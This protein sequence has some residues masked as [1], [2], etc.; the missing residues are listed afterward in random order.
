[1]SPEPRTYLRSQAVIFLVYVHLPPIFPD[2]HLLLLR[3]PPHLS[4]VALISQ[5]RGRSQEEAACNHGGKEG[6]TKEQKGVPCEMAPVGGCN[7]V[8]VGRWA[9]GFTLEDWHF[10]GDNG[11]KDGERMTVL[12]S[13]PGKEGV[14]EWIGAR[15]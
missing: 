4:I 8:I 13:T 7:G 11:V 3:Q 5:G 14:C 10:V 1:M 6:E 2:P 12:V 9:E 15:C